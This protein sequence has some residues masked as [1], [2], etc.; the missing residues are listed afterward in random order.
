[1]IPGLTKFL[2]GVSG[3]E[4]SPDDPPMQGR[5]GYSRIDKIEAWEDARGGGLEKYSPCV[6]SVFAPAQVRRSRAVSALTDA[7]AQSKFN[8]VRILAAEDGKKPGRGC[9]V[10]DA[11]QLEVIPR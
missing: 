4:E 8:A 10:A 3:F 2:L 5:I 9:A 6:T 11:G 7:G 1:M